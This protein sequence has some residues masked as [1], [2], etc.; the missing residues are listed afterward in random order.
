MISLEN[1]KC[2]PKIYLHMLILQTYTKKKI[3]FKYKHY[4]FNNIN[5]VNTMKRLDFPQTLNQLVPN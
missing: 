5:R 3:N 1:N 2:Q 4:I